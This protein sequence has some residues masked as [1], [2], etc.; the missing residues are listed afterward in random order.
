MDLL[1]GETIE[2][3]DFDLEAPGQYGAADQF[4][5]ELLKRYKTERFQHVEKLA[6]ATLLACSANTNSW[7]PLLLL[8][9]AVV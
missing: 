2:S 6:R 3:R 8:A 1:T 5:K 4:Q 9:R 7:K